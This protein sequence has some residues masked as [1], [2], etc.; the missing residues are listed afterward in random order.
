MR[1]AKSN[2]ADAR[3]AALRLRYAGSAMDRSGP[4]AGAS[5]AATVALV[6]GG[7]IRVGRAIVERLAEAGYRVWIHCR[8]SHD[9]ARA[10]AA[11]LGDAAL[12]V[13]EADLADAD[14]RARLCATVRGADGPA[15]GRLDV[16]VC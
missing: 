2:R 14:A 6:T 4:P 7:A 15:G 9:A 10:L 1:P 12:G 3:L 5:G 16:L 11:S 13:I 8:G